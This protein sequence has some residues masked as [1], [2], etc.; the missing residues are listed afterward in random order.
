MQE[1]FCRNRVLYN[2]CTVME[3]TRTVAHRWEEGT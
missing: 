3:L 2:I 1:M